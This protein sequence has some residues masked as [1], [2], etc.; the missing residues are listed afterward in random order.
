MRLLALALASLAAAVTAL[1]FAPVSV[2]LTAS[3]NGLQ[4]TLSL[5]VSNPA[6]GSPQTLAGLVLDTSTLDIVVTTTV[7]CAAMG[8]PA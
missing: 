6:G 2:P 3:A 4:Y 5:G 7:G 8:V 1:S